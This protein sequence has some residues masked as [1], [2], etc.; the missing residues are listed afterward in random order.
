MDQP[1]RI[2][3]YAIAFTVPIQ[4]TAATAKRVTQFLHFCNSILSTHLVVDRDVPM[5]RHT[6]INLLVLYFDDD[7]AQVIN[8][9]ESLRDTDWPAYRKPQALL[10]HAKTELAQCITVLSATRQYDG[11]SNSKKGYAPTLWG[12][13]LWH[14]LES[15]DDTKFSR[16]YLCRFLQSLFLIL[17]CSS[18]VSQYQTHKQ[19]CLD[20]MSYHEYLRCMR[21]FINNNTYVYHRPIDRRIYTHVSVLIGPQGESPVKN[22]VC[23]STCRQSSITFLVAS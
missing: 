4:P 16:D 21:S 10:L 15:V 3:L 5:N 9:M 8:V 19:A 20:N 17:P 22:I 6:L 14:V 13:P 18:C 2:V 23:L 12:P 1:L 11:I 7:I